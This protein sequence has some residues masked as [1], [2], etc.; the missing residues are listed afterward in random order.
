MLLSTIKPLE[1]NVGEIPK[2]EGRIVVVEGIVKN[3]DLTR[4]GNTIITLSD[5]SGEVK[6]FIYGKRNIFVGNRVKIMGR[7]GRY[8][9][10]FEIITDKIVVLN[11]EI[12]EIRLWQLAQ[13]PNL[14]INRDINTTG[15]VSAIYDKFMY[16]KD[17]DYMIEVVKPLENVEDLEEGK[18]VSVR[19]R[20]FFNPEKFSYHILS[21]EVKKIE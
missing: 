9:D 17:D 10:M 16:L 15:Y 5:A 2:Y 18:K 8:R 19:G 20:F 14:Y 21:I 6:V 7:V 3:V 1:V 4:G 12:T 11:P 13:N